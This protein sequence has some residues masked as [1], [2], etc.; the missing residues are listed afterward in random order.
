MKVFVSGADGMLGTNIVGELIRQGYEVRAFLLPGR[1]T[2][3]LDSFSIEKTFGNLLNADEVEKA[4]QGCD[5]VI[6]AAADTSVWPSRSKRVWAVNVDGTKNIVEAAQK[7]GIKRF[8]QVGSASS[9]GLGTKENPADENSPCA[10]KKYGLDYCDSKHEAQEYLLDKVRNENFPALI[11]TPTFMFGPYDSKPGSG[12]MILAIAEG[13]LPAYT[14]GGK[15][16]VYAKDVAV[17][18]VNGL[19]KGRVGEC[20]IAGNEN[21][22]FKEITSLIANEVNSK[23]PKMATPDAVIKLAGWLSSALGS[24]FK[25]EPR[26]SYPMALIACDGQYFSS[27]K[28]VRELNMPQTDIRIAVRETYK[29]FQENG[30]VES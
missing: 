29:W 3:S 2:K 28:A 13:K 19:K 23:P 20:Y 7:S 8:V 22:N 24:T 30:Y 10:S 9:F 1:T 15:N 21:L 6:H 14:S 25:F 17:A 16:F 27:Q 26:I 4:I 18:V 11:V 5:A 12:K